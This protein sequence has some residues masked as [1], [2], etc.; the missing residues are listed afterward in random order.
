VRITVERLQHR[1]E[2]SA[3]AAIARLEHSFEP[4][5][6]TMITGPSG[7]GKSTLLAILA[8]LL[9]PSE[10]RLSW[11]GR[12]ML[13]LDDA[14]RTTLRARHAGFV[15]QD[16]LLDLSRTARDNVLEAAALSGL[17]MRTA[18]RDATILLERFGVADLADR[19]PGKTSGGQAQRIALCRA[20]IKRPSVVFADEPTGNLD[21]VSAATVWQALSTAANEG[22]TVI[23]ATHDIVRA[24]A[25]PQHLELDAP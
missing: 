22:A 4:G 11:Q 7:S 17:D 9:T 16:A 2:P 13:R 8:L 6:L 18:R 14:E 10:G 20:L 23:V 12:D 25:A 3:P 1:Y 15:F 19:L 5:T 21:P 24:R